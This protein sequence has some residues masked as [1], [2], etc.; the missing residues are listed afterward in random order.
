MFEIGVLISSDLSWSAHIDQVVI[1][2]KA[3]RTL[4]FI[5]RKFYRNQKPSYSGAAAR[6]YNWGGG[7]GGGGGGK[8]Y[9]TLP[10]AVHRGA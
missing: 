3:R 5:Y 9:Y 6:I 4:G 1:A 7:G 8:I 2:S 10:E